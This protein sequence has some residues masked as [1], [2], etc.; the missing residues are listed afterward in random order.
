MKKIL[1]LLLLL[2]VLCVAGIYRIDGMMALGIAGVLLWICLAFLSW[3]RRKRLKL[4]FE[5]QIAITPRQKKAFC[6]LRAENTGRFAIPRFR[7]RLQYRYPWEKKQKKLYVYGSLGGR[8]VQLSRVELPA[9][10]C[11]F[12]HLQL[13]KIRVY[14]WFGL[15]SSWARKTKAQGILAVLPP[16]REMRVELSYR[17]AADNSALLLRSLPQQIGDSEEIRQLRE[18]QEGDHTRN[19]HWKQTARTEKLWVKEF[20]Q[21]ADRLV[22]LHLVWNQFRFSSPSQREGFYVILSALVHGLLRTLPQVPVYWTDEGGRPQGLTLTGEAGATPLL[23]QLYHLEQGD[24]L[25]LHHPA[26]PMA[27]AGRILQLDFTIGLQLREKNQVLYTFSPK[28]FEQQL[29][30]FTLRL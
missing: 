14:D 10:Y 12:L 5:K 29:S 7:A 23:L 25:P 3:R 26:P 16:V 18:Y 11:G 20:E 24:S 8:E 28:Q 9:V 1:Y 22:E 27:P 17:S 30:H 19:I 21:E 4:G 13:D 6:T 2:V 15:T